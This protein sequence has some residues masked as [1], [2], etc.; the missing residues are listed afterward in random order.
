[1][2]GIFISYRR[3][4]TPWCA[5]RLHDVLSRV[6][7]PHTIFMDVESIEGGDQFKARIAKGIADSEVV[8]VLIGRRWLGVDAAT[9]RRR[10]DDP[11]DFVQKEIAEALDQGKA[12]VPVLVDDATL[13]ARAELPESMARIV[14]RQAEHLRYADFE[15]DSRALVALL[16]HTVKRPRAPW[17][18]PTLTPARAAALAGICIGMTVVG[19]L[20]GAGTSGT[21]SPE[22]Q[23]S[24]ARQEAY[25]QA[26]QDL[27]N[28]I[29]GFV[30]DADGRP[31]VD[32]SVTAKIG[33]AIRQA[34]TVDG[35]IYALSIADLKP[36]LNDRVEVSAR[37]DSFREKKVTFLYRDGFRHT[38]I[39]AK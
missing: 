38:I 32:A 29:Q 12:V 14:D 17:R 26:R 25:Q 11:K 39:L 31:V 19:F 27:R 24:E 36:Q 7:D 33:G 4:D 10:I 8:I 28:E 37:A 9:G 23:G 15:Q 2:G 16:E 30:F 18:L 6:F 13:P 3:D 1:M 34:T 35:G 22:E 21:I 20:A 5:G